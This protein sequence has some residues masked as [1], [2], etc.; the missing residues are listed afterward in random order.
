MTVLF[1]CTHR[2][3]STPI[4]RQATLHQLL[5][6]GLII[7]AHNMDHTTISYQ[8]VMHCNIICSP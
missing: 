1:Q 8:K 5:M 7:M 3:S 4:R 2:S 6:L